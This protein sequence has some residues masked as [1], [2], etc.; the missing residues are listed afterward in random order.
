MP[1]HAAGVPALC[2]AVVVVTTITT[3]DKFAL[4]LAAASGAFLLLAAFIHY[5]D[6]VVPVLIVAMP[7]EISKALFPFLLLEKGVSGEPVSIVSFLRIGLVT[8]LLAFL[9][10]SLVRGKLLLPRHRI[11]AISLA[12]LACYLVSA[13]FISPATRR[14]VIEVVRVGAEFWLAIAV[15][16]WLDSER[17]ITLAMRTLIA[18]AAFIACV[19]ILQWLTGVLFWNARLIHTGF[20]RINV[21]FADPNILARYLAV[22]IAA[23]FALL[24]TGIMR[25]EVLIGAMVVE[26]LACLMTFSRSGWLLMPLGIGIVLWRARGREGHG[27]QLIFAVAAFAL[28]GATFRLSGGLGKRAASLDLG[29]TALG[30]RVALIDTGLRIFA[31][32]PLFGAGLGG[33]QTVAERFYRQALPYQGKY[34]TLSHTAFVTTTAEL[35]LPGAILTVWWLLAAWRSLG[36][37]TETADAWL[38]GCALASVSGICVIFVSAQSEG[39]FFEEPMLWMLSGLLMAIERLSVKTHALHELRAAE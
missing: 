27:R 15:V 35:G 2:I 25:D 30:P 14:A 7:L 31:E 18:W 12:L 9:L 36:N 17:R 4:A 29:V 16:F 20:T 38:T 10:S 1:G 6:F 8:G 13:L 11:V 22:A 23:D 28:I 39:R 33:F 32:H 21:T 19:G 3:G 26:T 5:P 37:V 24:R 34:V